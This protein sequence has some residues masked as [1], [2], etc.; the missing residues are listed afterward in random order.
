M[1]TIE[2][3]NTAKIKEAIKNMAENQKSLRNF[4]KTENFKGT[5]EERKQMEPWQAVLQHRSNREK[6]RIL[7]AAYGLMRGKA[8]SKIENKYS[9]DNHP[10][11]EFIDKINKVISAYKEMEE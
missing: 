2:K 9:E 11:N 10:L 3:V 5:P 1:E 4:R 6:L 7:Y 8:F